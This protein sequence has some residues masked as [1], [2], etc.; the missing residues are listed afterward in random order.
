M[1]ESI[2]IHLPLFQRFDCHNCGYCCR[3]LV[4]NISGAERETILQ[5][6]WESHIPDHRLFIRYLY[7][8][9][10]TWCLAKRSDG[11]CVF[12]REDGL[13]RLHAESGINTKPLAC[14][15]YPFVPRPGG[16]IVHIDLRA[17]CPSVASNKGRNLTVHTKEIKQLIIETGTPAQTDPPMGRNLRQLSNEEFSSMAM[18]F[19][20]LLRKGSLPMRTRLLAGCYLLDLLYTIRVQKVCDD[21]FIELMELLSASAIE[22]AQRHSDNSANQIPQRAHKLFR[23]WLFLH[24][25]SEDPQNLDA[26]PIKKITQ[27]WT[28]YGQARRFTTGVGFIP[29]IIPGWPTTD[30]QTVA[31]IKKGP[32]ETLEPVCRSMRVKLEAHAFAGANYYQYDAIC[33]LTA[34]WLSIA[35]TGWFSRMAAISKGHD[36]LTT[37]DLLAGLR[38]THHTFGVSP[39]FARFSERWRIRAL[40]HIGTPTALLNLYGP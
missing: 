1:A 39:A 19:E 26:G 13:C 38:Q 33:G 23:Q 4:V 21:R 27:S 12:L 29:C 10:R 28:R 9:R 22:E 7:K 24:A 30:F 5:A 32:D 40:A 35:V 15:I 2:R 16:D 3:H 18:A 20:G 31:Q 6:G 25:V 36:T 14:R 17:D 11:C 34:L 37:D 8:G